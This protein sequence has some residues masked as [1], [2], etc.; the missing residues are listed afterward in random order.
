[1]NSHFSIIY[2]F[3]LQN[4]ISLSLQKYVFRIISRIYPDNHRDFKK[5]NTIV[6]KSY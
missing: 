4:I 3:F 6:N 5:Y 2:F 1:M